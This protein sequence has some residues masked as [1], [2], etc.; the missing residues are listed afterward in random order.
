MWV[1]I[2]CLAI[3]QTISAYTYQPRK[4]DLPAGTVATSQQSYEKLHWLMEHTKPGQFFF[5]AAWPGVYL[6]LQLRNPAFVDQ[7][8]PG[9]QSRPEEVALTIQQLDEKRVPYVLWAARL[10]SMDDLSS[11]SKDHVVPL[12]AYLHNRYSQVHT[13][14]DGDQVWQRNTS[15]IHP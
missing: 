6:P 13:F 10:G 1:G 8:Y 15:A 3:W 7:I 14:P 2:S 12:R 5:Q 4:I 11:H 9:D